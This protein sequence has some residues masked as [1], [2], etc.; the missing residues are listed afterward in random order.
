[1]TQEMDARQAAIMPTYGRANLSFVRGKGCWLYTEDGTAYLDCT[2]GI[3]VNIF[4]HGCERL[5]KAL[6][7]Q[8]DQL[9]HTSNLYRI[10]EQERLALRL[11]N[12]ARLDHVFFCNSGV[13]AN[14]AAVK[15]ARRYH[16]KRGEK[17]RIKII[18]ASG[19]FHGRTLGMLA[20]TDKPL[21]REGFGP[22]PEGFDHVPFGNLNHLRDSMSAEVAAI[23]IEPVQGEG[24]ASVAPKGY[25]EGLRSAADEYGALLIADEVQ[26]GMG[27]TG[28]MFAYQDTDIQP[29]LVVL[30]KGLGG[31][32]PVGAVIARKAIGEAMGPGSHG[33]TF[34]GNPLAM[35]AANAVLDGLE[36]EGFLADV[37]RR[38]DILSHHLFKLADA[39]PDIIKSVRGT[40]FL[41]GLVL[42]DSLPA[43]E[44]GE[45]LRLKQH[46]LFVPAAQNVLR[47]L[48]PLT[49]TEDELDLVYQGLDGFF[50]ARISGQ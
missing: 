45:A 2:S 47:L 18:C 22:M 9:W 14:E 20:A 46:M 35:A 42:A 12:H 41:R 31:G 13:E 8:L 48:P 24:G 40:G 50:A 23:I 10:P 38:A 3:G 17:N 29:D 19:A 11:A 34:G 36:E 25:L 7:S 5:N 39:Y 30:A 44:V 28:R 16:Y 4:G 33:S 15:M 27:R 1:M 6:R 32:F 49:I 21:F 43:G 26:S 37:R